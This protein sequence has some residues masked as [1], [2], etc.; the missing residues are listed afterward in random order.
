VPT[1]RGWATFGAGLAMWIAARLI[2]SRDLHMI[3]TGIAILPLLAIGLVRWS[4]PK[5]GVTRHL[6]ASRAYPGVRVTVTLSIENRSRGTTPYLLL[7]DA[8]PAGLGSPARLV[9]TSIPPRNE[10]KVAYSIVARHRGRYTIG[11]LSV[12]QTDPFGLAR[13]KALGGPEA[14]LVVYP[15]VEDLD[16]RGLVSQGAGSGEAAARRL[17]RAAAEFFTMREYVTGDDLRRIHWPSVAKTGKL[18]IRQDE[19]TR[20]SSAILLLDTR[21]V[22]LGPQGSPGFEAAVSATASIGRA[23]S[24][25]GFAVRLGTVDVPARP[26]TEEVMLDLLAGIGASRTPALVASLTGLRSSSSADTTL[27]VVTAPPNGAEVAA[28]C[29]VGTAFGRKVVVLTYPMPVASLPPE[30]VVELDGRATVARASLQRAGWD[31][32]ILHP[33]GKLADTWRRTK[34]Q[35]L[36]VAGSLS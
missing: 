9:V 27:A 17:H 28:L 11:P 24:R 36:Q 15:T 1:R 21:S 3:A 31:V 7:E 32:V 6:S 18:M 19:S 13:T 30:A 2:G 26:V 20:R 16:A 14:E 22:V 10:H 25:S 5:I 23:L 29:R 34:T 8:L 35:K 33:E 12:Y 4:H